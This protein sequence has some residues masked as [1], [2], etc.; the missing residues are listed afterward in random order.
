[1]AKIYY[2]K[3]ADLKDLGGRK[4]AI[5]GYATAASRSSWA[6]P[7]AAARGRAPKRRN[8]AS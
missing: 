3:D 7:K 1:M 4:I 8:C 2:D 5:L 6:C